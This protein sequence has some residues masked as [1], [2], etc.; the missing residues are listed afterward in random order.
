MKRFIMFTMMVFVLVSAVFAGGKVDVSTVTSED[1]ARLDKIVDALEPSYAIKMAL[2]NFGNDIYPMFGY[3]KLQ[4]VKI[5]AIFNE[6]GITFNQFSNYTTTNPKLNVILARLSSRYS[7]LG[8]INTA[9]VETLK[10]ILDL[11]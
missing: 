4:E 10:K 5:N 3:R 11:L 8:S 2:E 7:Y 1:I 9:D 6:Y